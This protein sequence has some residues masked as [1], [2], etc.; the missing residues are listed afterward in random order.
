MRDDCDAGRVA[1]QVHVWQ[2]VAHV[3]RPATALNRVAV[4][5]LAIRRVAP[6]LDLQVVK[7]C[8]GVYVACG[9]LKGR[10]T[11]PEVDVRERVA[12]IPRVPPPTRVRVTEPEL[13]PA[14]TAPALDAAIRKDGAHVN[15]VVAPAGD[16]HHRA[17]I[18]PHVDAVGSIH[19]VPAPRVVA[20]TPEPTQIINHARVSNVRADLDCRA[21]LPNVD[22]GQVIAHLAWL[23]AEPG[24][25]RVRRLA[26]CPIRVAAKA[27][28]AA[29]VQHSADVAVARCDLDRVAAG[30][31]VDE[32]QSVAHFPS[33]IPTVIVVAKPE[34]SAS[35][36]ALEPTRQCHPV[37]N[38][39]AR[40]KAA[41]GDLH[42][43][44]I[45]PEIDR[46]HFRPEAAATCARRPAVALGHTA[47]S[48][49]L[50]QL[51]WIPE[52]LELARRAVDGAHVRSRPRQLH[53][54]RAVAIVVKIKVHKRQAVSHLVRLVAAV[55]PSA[56]RCLL[57][58]NRKII[59]A[60]A[61]H[62]FAAPAPA[63]DAE[64]RP[65]WSVRVIDAQLDAVPRLCRNE[66]SAAKRFGEGVARQGGSLL[67]F[68]GA[69]SHL[70]PRRLKGQNGGQG[71]Q[72]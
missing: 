12:H 25:G 20:P 28:D 21:A 24:V 71:P 9:N 7:Q 67:T 65:A 59:W 38:N 48:A 42:G 33:V 16:L 29:V 18:R 68:R 8:A 50:T 64:P 57:R 17:S 23:V 47:A 60:D 10:P 3:A 27:L 66:R 15:R 19:Q 49:E 34:V 22:A 31:K 62:A 70:D 32:R 1:R 11:R 72:P 43:P 45:R 41:G 30:P 2:L 44:L 5:Q 63:L 52:A 13:A 53:R 14:V 36:K 35:A 39:D 61:V 69:G 51:V 4:A 26:A 56:R 58:I 37:L 55:V 6:A 46:I 40:H 54:T